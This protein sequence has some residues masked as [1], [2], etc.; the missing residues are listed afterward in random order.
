MPYIEF[1]GP[2]ASG[3]TSAAREMLKSNPLLAPGRRSLALMVQRH[4]VNRL[5]LPPEGVRIWANLAYVLPATLLLCLRYWRHTGQFNQ[6]KTMMI[7]LLKSRALAG[8]SNHWVVD[9]GLQQHISSAVA[10]RLLS[11]H[12]AMYWRKLCLED[13]WRP[14]QLIELTASADELIRRVKGSV[15]HTRQCAAE[16][17]EEYVARH[18]GAFPNQEV[19]SAA[20]Q[21]GMPGVPS[22]RTKQLTHRASDEHLSRTDPDDPSLGLTP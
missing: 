19:R 7:L 15:K 22:S 5:G 21:P 6:A 3:K 16:T 20:T 1:T 9:Q 13:P 17:P 14:Q 11:P 10:N 4:S 12:H 8:S 2:P 18:V